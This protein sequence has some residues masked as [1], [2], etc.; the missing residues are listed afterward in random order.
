[1]F[2]IRKKLCFYWKNNVFIRKENNVFIGK[3]MYILEKKMFLLEKQYFFI[4]KKARGSRDGVH[5]L[6]TVG[7]NLNTNNVWFWEIIYNNLRNNK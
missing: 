7:Q 2:F 1:M 6:L 4:R 5:I 3:T